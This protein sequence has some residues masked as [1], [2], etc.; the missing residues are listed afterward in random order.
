MFTQTGTEAQIYIVM[1]SQEGRYIKIKNEKQNTEL[2]ISN[3]YLEPDKQNSYE[4]LIPE[5]VRSADIIGG[6]LNKKQVSQF[7]LMYIIFIILE[8]K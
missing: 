8:K 5:G 3:I 4:K 7:I 1:K 6:G 2:T